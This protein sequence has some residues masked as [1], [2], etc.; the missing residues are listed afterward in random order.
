MVP[1]LLDIFRAGTRKQTG[2]PQVMFYPMAHVPGEKD[3]FLYASLIM[4]YLPLLSHYGETTF[5]LNV[6]Y[7]QGTP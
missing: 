4:T 6:G 7:L 1:L 3:S 5:S 2:T